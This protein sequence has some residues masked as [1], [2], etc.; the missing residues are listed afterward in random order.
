M[1]KIYSG[2]IRMNTHMN[3]TLII[4]SLEVMVVHSYLILGNIL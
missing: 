2:I 1:I 3:N 4:S